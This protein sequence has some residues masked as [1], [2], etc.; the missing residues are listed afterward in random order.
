MDLPLP[1]NLN[2]YRYNIDSNQSSS[3]NQQP[4]RYYL[5]ESDVVIGRIYNEFYVMIIRQMTLQDEM[6]K[7]TRKQSVLGD[8]RT[9]N[10]R[11]PLNSGYSEIAM[12]KLLT[13]SPAKKTNILKINLSGRFTLNI[14]DELIIVHHRQSYSSMIFDIK[15][16]GEFDGYVT[17]NFPIIKKAT[18]KATEIPFAHVSNEE[19]SDS[20]GASINGKFSNA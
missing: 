18:I 11:S 4:N 7:P 20:A 5:N 19:N 6:P 2:K 9:Q 3:N 10:R 14:I 13:D 15:M 12:Y 16:S 17:C 1:L 8:K